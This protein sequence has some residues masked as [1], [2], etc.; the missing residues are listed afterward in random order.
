MKAFVIGDK[1]VVL[2]F[3]LVGIKGTSVSNKSEALDALSSTF[4]MK[5]I[6]IVLVTD[7]FSSQI[8]DKIDKFRSKSAAP[9]IIS[10]PSRLEAVGEPSSTNRLMREIMR[11]RV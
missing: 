7:D 6:G 3:R 11:I 9:M 8:Q 4:N 5:D 2:S 1:S 10:I